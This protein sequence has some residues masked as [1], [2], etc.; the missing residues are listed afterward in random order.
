[1][2][3][4]S[5][6]IDSDTMNETFTMNSSDDE[7]RELLSATS[8]LRRTAGRT[9]T[10]LQA[11]DVPCCGDFCKVPHKPVPELTKGGHVCCFCHL[12]VHSVGFGCCKGPL[13]EV[14]EYEH[15]TKLPASDRMYLPREGHVCLECDHTGAA[16]KPITATTAT[17]MEM[18]T[19]KGATTDRSY[20]C[21]SCLDRNT[22]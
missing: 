3:P 4:A 17:A 6:G 7:E 1:M 9:S 15:R 13:D 18:M 11:E 5:T 19:D 21:F 14:L 20:R 22:G 8:H 10:S 16:A 12:I 2:R